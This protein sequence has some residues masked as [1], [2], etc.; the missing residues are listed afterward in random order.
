MQS[1]ERAVVAWLRR[2][3]TRPKPAYDATIET[4]VDVSQVILK[5]RLL[6]NK[7]D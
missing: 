6:Y 7:N 4:A 2:R 3:T 1:D 5:S